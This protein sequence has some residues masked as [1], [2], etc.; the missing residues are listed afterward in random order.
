MTKK[1]KNKT[2][3]YNSKFELNF[4]EEE[5]KGIEDGMREFRETF[6]FDFDRLAKGK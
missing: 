4:T 5:L 2:R 6:K 3:T 1:N